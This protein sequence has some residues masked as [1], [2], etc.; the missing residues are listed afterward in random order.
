MN[1][2]LLKELEL[3]NEN[4]KKS[5]NDESVLYNIV[6]ELYNIN[7][8]NLPTDEQSV[9][10]NAVKLFSIYL[11]L[12][13]K[14]NY[15]IM[16]VYEIKVKYDL[17]KNRLDYLYEKMRIIII[18][19]DENIKVLKNQEQRNAY[20]DYN[21]DNILSLMNNYDDI[22]IKINYII[23]ILKEKRIIIKLYINS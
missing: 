18:N 16:K 22:N 3:I 21:L 7:I 14:I 10:I 8:P 11:E 15:Y 5:N 9:Y 12:Y 17:I 23:N 1:N 4:L 20:V 13:N 19:T 2:E 6:D